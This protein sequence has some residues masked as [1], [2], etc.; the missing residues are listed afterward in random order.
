MGKYSAKEIKQRYDHLK[1]QRGVWETH[2]Q[3]LADFIQPRKNNINRTTTDGEKKNILLLDNSGV[4]SNELLAGAL[5][6]LLTSPN[7][8]WF[9]LTTGSDEL[10]Q[11]DSIRLFLQNSAK[12]M[13]TVLN[14]SNFQTEVHELYLDLCCFGTAPMAI[15][16]DDDTIIRFGA[17][18]IGEFC[19]DEN[20]KGIIDEVYREFEWTARKIVEEFGVENVNKKVMD[21]FKKNSEE[22][23]KIIHAVYPQT[24]VDGKQRGRFKYQSQYI[25]HCD[26]HELESKGFMELP[27]VVPRWSKT[28]DEVY[29]RSPGMVALP[30]IRT[31]N[32]MTYVTLV[33]AQKVI[34]PPLQAPDDGFIIPM[35]THPGGL[36]YYRSGSQDRIEPIM[37]DARIDFGYQ[38]MTDRRTR[39][40]ESFYVDQLQLSQ[41]PQMTA[42]EVNARTEEKMRLLGP[43]LGRMQSEFLKPLIDRCFAIMLRRRMFPDIPQALSGQKLTVRYSSMIARAQRFAEA[44]N[45]TRTIQTI[46]P[47]VQMDQTVMD[48]FN[49]DAAVRNIAGIYALPQELIRS[50]KEVKGI[51]DA[52]AKAQQEAVDMQKQAAESGQAVAQST[53][54]KNLASASTT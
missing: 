28:T 25:L 36:N 22:K 31:L 5:H 53:A 16:E 6:G 15:E 17:K 40:R 11:D 19:V 24:R 54:V 33:G 47:F 48:N 21:M 45:I 27:F 4:Q 42:T 26:E 18:N 35:V 3:D 38:A 12:K 2:W 8:Q 1:G 41:G 10:D 7:A 51:R 32:K 43:M 29:G 50:D 39:V 20:N 14:E 13:H 44:Q 30:E 46:S 9:E 34:D 37:S 23:L 49:G 52:R